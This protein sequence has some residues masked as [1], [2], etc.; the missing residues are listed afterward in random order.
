MELGTKG[1]EMEISNLVYTP[2][3][4]QL[5]NDG[6]WVGDLK[7][8]PGVELLVVG[9]SSEAV[10]K[11]RKQK[12]E[13]LRLRLRNAEPSDEQLERVGHELMYEVVLK[14]WKG[15]KQ[16]GEELEYTQEL[17]KKFITDAGGEAFRSLI[18]QA[19]SQLDAQASYLAE[20]LKKS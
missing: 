12:T 17:A 7:G 9:M 11:A 20:D 15:L 14:G 1:L 2:D 16:N 5:I 19:A 13:A 4:M 18:V 6:T 3:A 8:A 10:R